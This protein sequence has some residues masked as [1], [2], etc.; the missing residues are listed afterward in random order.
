[1]Y[2]RREYNMRTVRTKVYKFDELSEEAQE[3]A[4]EQFSDINVDY[5]WYEFVYDDFSEI[6]KTIGIS[7]DLKRTYFSGFYHQGSGSSFTAD[8]DLF[9]LI[10]GIENKTYLDYAPNLEKENRFRPSQL[11]I[12]KRVLDLIK[13]GWIDVSC[14]IVPT[15]RETSVKVD[16]SSNYSYNQCVNY[17]NID[18]EIENLENWMIEIADDLN[19]LL[20][21]LLEKEYEY[22]TSKDAIIETIKAN[23]YEFHANGKQYY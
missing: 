21:N 14:D 1:V 8:I 15:N 11:N 16:F 10:K 19:S 5:D 7:V 17:N 12:G 23:E 3:I 22:K 20:Y 4:I 6:C 18:A 13:R 9:N 2:N